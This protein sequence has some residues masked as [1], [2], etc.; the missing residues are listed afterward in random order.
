M[1]STWPTS[2]VPMPKAKAPKAPC[3]LVWLSPQT[4]VMPGWV[5]PIS[6]PTTC[7]MPWMGPLMSHRV[8]P[9]SSQ[10]S[11]SVRTCVAASTGQSEMSV[12]R[13]GMA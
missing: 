1:A 9:N 2:L 11:R 8:M 13:V 3:V 4:M 10:F 12:L 5:T 6:G 7:T